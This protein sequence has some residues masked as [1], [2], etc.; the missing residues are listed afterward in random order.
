MR[1]T[2]GRMISERFGDPVILLPRTAVI[3]ALAARVPADALAVN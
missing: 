3:D 1:S 2:T